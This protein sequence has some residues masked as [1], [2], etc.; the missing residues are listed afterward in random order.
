MNWLRHSLFCI[1]L[2][3][4]PVVLHGA[5]PQVD[6][7]L[8]EAGIESQKHDGLRVTSESVMS[9]ARPVIYAQNMKLVEALEQRGIRARGI[10]H[11]VFQCDYLDREKLGL[12]GEITNV[13]LDALYSA[14]RGGALPVMTCLGESKSGQ[15][16]NINADIAARELVWGT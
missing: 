8:T 13:N 12:V 6:K 9:V 15:V 4:R 10:Q 7:A 5:G 1:A 11:G 14:V 2:G 16:L 3:L